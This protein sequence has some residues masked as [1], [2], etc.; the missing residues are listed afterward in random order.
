[1]ANGL[2]KGKDSGYIVTKI[3]K[4]AKPSKRKGVSWAM[5]AKV[6]AIEIDN[7]SWIRSGRGYSITRF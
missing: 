1:M 3:D 2:A 5:D 4:K 7:S 6:Y